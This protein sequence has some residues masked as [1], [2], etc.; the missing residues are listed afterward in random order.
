MLMMLGKVLKERYL[1]T[2]PET[3]P[4]ILSEYLRKRQTLHY[5]T[6]NEDCRKTSQTFDDKVN[7]SNTTNSNSAPPCPWLF[8]HSKR[9]FNTTR[10]S[11]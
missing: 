6:S 5:T 8:V 9:R 3:V 10:I 4:G 7:L 11:K 1:Q 2:I